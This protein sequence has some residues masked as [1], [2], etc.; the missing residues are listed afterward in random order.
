M[1]KT[2]LF[3][4]TLTLTWLGFSQPRPT[5]EELRE[6]L[7]DATFNEKF[8]V[9][10]N[11][12]FDN[13]YAEA[14]FVWEIILE[15]DPTN[16]NVLYKYG[17]CLV[18]LNREAEAL[19]YF[20]KAQYSVVKNYNPYSPL[21][22]NAPPELYFYLA[23]SSHIQGKIDT[24]YF[25]YDFFLA[26][27]KKKHEKYDLAVLGMSQVEVARKLMADP[28]PYII[29]NIG[30]IVNT[31]NPEYS[32]VVT[33]DGTA[34]F[35]TSKRMRPDSSNQRYVNINN[36]MHYE[37]IYVS[38][39]D[40]DGS[41]STPK[42][43]DFCK[44]NKNDASI[45]V[46]PDGTTV[47]VYQDLRGGDIYFSELRDTVFVNIE[48]FPAEELNTD[49]WETH[50]T[51]SPDGNYVYFVSD[52]PGGMGGRDI[53]RLKKLP[54]GSWSKAMN[55]GPP[56][57]TAYDEDSPF[58]GA[59]NK[60]MYFS[61]N[62]PNSMGGFDIFVTQ[63][64]E[65]EQWSE[66]ENMGYPLNSVDDDIF[67]T[68]TADGYT[69]FYSSDKL[70][71]KG[72]KD[73]YMVQ[74]ESSFIRNV[75]ILTGYIVTSDHS[76]I[77]LGITIRVK[78]LTD[79]GPVKIY[80]PRRRDGGYVLNL[81]PC[82]TYHLDYLLD[83][84]SFYQTEL[85]IPCNSSYQEIKH[86]LLLDMVNLEGAP[87]L[88][89]PVS[90]TRWEFTNSEYI[91]N[92]EGSQ[93]SIYEDKELLYQEK[94]NKYG[95]FPYKELDPNKSHLMKID[96][97]DFE[98]CEDLVLNLVDSSNNILDTYTFNS[99]C[100]TN[101]SAADYSEILTTPIFQYNF[102]YNKDEFSTK[103]K[104]L[105]LYVQGIKQV[106]S[107]GKPVTI[108]ISSSASKVPTKSYSNN[109]ELADKRLKTGKS[110]LIKVL[111]AENV[112][113]D[114]ITFVEK[115]SLVQGPD[116]NNDAEEKANVYQRYQYIKFEIQF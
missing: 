63:M 114:M 61:S 109:Q 75:A 99:N 32:P 56:V 25:Q 113:L 14:M 83:S 13:V 86:E 111:K 57:N 33:I 70:D 38:Y 108:Y 107:S 21:E 76:M 65:A 64:D 31:E 66:P 44:V 8:D 72:D 19:P 53:Y 102:G 4:L 73:I 97:A 36:G 37:D 10:N 34:L 58:M 84:T 24:A 85:Y 60:T 29:K 74:S 62:G 92:L 41:W 47:F 17:M 27:V 59:D 23:K 54:D 105:I 2:G 49:S 1:L 106:I 16:A 6:D 11:L 95:Q 7:K 96:D 79:D 30:P 87:L 55:L 43:L 67:Y 88:N 69:G 45:S 112:N 12:M 78:D 28:K 9:A 104:A 100:Q 50:A 80:R 71:G 98:F 46:S 22:R 48:P 52:R 68:T 110:I 42:Y 91:N 35:F 90:D 77:P 89:L 15:E 40:M 26:N 103:N 5:R 39:R 82:H 94:I 101:E 51:I 81:I 20:E 18:H 3:I 93:I 116:Y 115:E